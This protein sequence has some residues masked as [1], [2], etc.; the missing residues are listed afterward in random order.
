MHYIVQILFWLK[1]VIS[2]VL[3][4]ALLGGVVTLILG[5][6]NVYIFSAFLCAGVIVGALW[7]ERTRRKYGLTRFHSKL[8][9]TPD[10]DGYE[11]GEDN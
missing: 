9:A 4:S 6:F 3:I 11:E 2:P 7:A 1:I 5:K 8:I 10:I